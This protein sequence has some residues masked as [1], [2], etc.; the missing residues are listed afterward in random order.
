MD[1]VM[2]QL[3]QLDGLGSNWAGDQQQGAEEE[4]KPIDPWG[5]ESFDMLAQNSRRKEPERARPLTSM[6]LPHHDE[7][8]ET[9]S[10]GS[11]QKTS[12]QNGHH[13]RKQELPE[14]SNYVE[15]MEK[16]LRNMHQH[17]VSASMAADIDLDAENNDMP[18][19]PP[20]KGQLYQ[21]PKSS[22]GDPR[23]PIPRMARPETR[24]TLAPRPK[25]VRGVFGVAF[26]PAASAQ[27]VLEAWLADIY[28]P[29]VL[30]TYAKE[31]WNVRTPLSQASPIIAVMLA[32]WLEDH[33]GHGLGWKTT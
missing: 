30:W 10:G 18:P 17:S 25:A 31:S 33:N 32:M 16:R 1:S 5:P 4:E 27:K 3:D 11:S 23:E 2:E 26:P 22:A 20:P 29:V 13:E 12:Y 15:R 28:E 21:R 8:Y 24:V 6:G 9:W 14:L 19:P 7:G